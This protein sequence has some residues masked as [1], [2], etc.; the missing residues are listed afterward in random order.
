MLDGKEYLAVLSGWGG[1]S[2]GMQ[3]QLNGMFPGQYPEVPE[4]GSVWV[5]AIE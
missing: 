2:R 4:G 3:N 5:F 1:D